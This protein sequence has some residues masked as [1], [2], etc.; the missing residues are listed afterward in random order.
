M[1][2]VFPRFRGQVERDVYR[3]GCERI[4]ADAVFLALPHGVAAEFAPALLQRGIKVLDLSAD[5][6]LKS[7]AVYK[8]FYEHEH[9]APDLLKQSV[10]GLPEMGTSPPGS[11]TT[12]FFVASHQS[13][14]QFCSNNVTGMMTAPAFALV[15]VCCVMSAHCRFSGDRQVK[16]SSR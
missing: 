12:A 5:F 6:R 4:D 10:Y 7:A 16:V 9:P 2:E 14:V 13:S 8:E 15:S 3:A 1:A 11:I